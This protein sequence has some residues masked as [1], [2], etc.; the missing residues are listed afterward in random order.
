MFLRPPHRFSFAPSARQVKNDPPHPLRGHL[1]YAARPPLRSS[2]CVFTSHA[3]TPMQP[4]SNACS[5]CV[6]SFAVTPRSVVWAFH[7]LFC[8]LARLMHSYF[9]CAF[10]SSLAA[11]QLPQALSAAQPIS[12]RARLL[13]QLN[14]LL[15]LLV[16]RRAVPRMRVARK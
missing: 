8:L 9:C 15:L 13:A 11:A 10:A 3:A 5:A 16:P 6:K 2:C 14:K 4:T 7:I 1:R 12:I